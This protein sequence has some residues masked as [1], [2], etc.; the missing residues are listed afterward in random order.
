[1]SSFFTCG[2]VDMISISSGDECDV[3]K[4]ESGRPGTKRK[5]SWKSLVQSKRKRAGSQHNAILDPSTFNPLDQTAVH[6]NA[7]GVATAI[8]NHLN[9]V[10]TDV[11]SSKLRLAAA[12][13]L[14]ASNRDDILRPFCT[15]EAGLATVTDIVESLTRPLDFDERHDEFL[16]L[17]HSAVTSLNSL[18]PGMRVTGRVENVT[19]FGAFCDIGVQQNAYV[20]RHEYPRPV[21]NRGPGP[22]GL[23][24]LH[25]GDRIA[26]FV[27]EVNVA[28][29]R[30]SLNR[31]TV[32]KPQSSIGDNKGQA[33]V[34]AAFAS[35]TTTKITTATDDDPVPITVID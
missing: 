3:L 23:F 31:V 11:G 19:T 22:D 30:I 13:L 2:D 25:L 34:V 33:P 9:F 29:N 8:I 5:T 16:P 7:Y 32:T 10:L 15:D 26:A 14:H 6:P 21:D 27:S 20:P 12:K 4:V 35:K 17:F 18:Q 28:Q 1:M 24:T